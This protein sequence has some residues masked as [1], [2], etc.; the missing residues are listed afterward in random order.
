MERLSTEDYVK[1]CWADVEFYVHGVLDN[2]LVV[3]KY[4]R[5]AVE[6]F[7]EDVNSEQWDYRPDRIEKVFSFFSFLNVD[8]KNSYV[9][10]PLLPF[11]AFFLVNVFGFYFPD[12]EKR[13]YRE[14]LLFIG[15]KNG[16]T[17]FSAAIQLFGLLG[18]GVSV[19]QSLLLSNTAKQA[20]N[21]LNYAKDI[22]NH[23]PALSKRLRPLRNKIVFNDPKR[24][25]F[26]EIFSTVEPSRLE[27]FSPSMAILDEIHGFTDANVFAAIKTGVGART[28]PLILL[29]TTAG[30]KNIGFCNDYLTYHKNLLDGK[31]TDPTAFSLIYQPDESDDLSDPDCWVKANPA[32]GIINSLDDLKASYNQAIHSYVDKYNFI[33][34]H[35]NIFWD[36]PDVWIPEDVLAPLFNDF[37]EEKLKGRDAYIGI[38]LSKTTDLSSVVVLIPDDENSVT[39]VIPKF[40]FANRPDNYIRSNGLDLTPWLTQGFIKKCDTKVID[41]DLIYEDI[42]KLAQQFNIVELSYDPYNAPQLIARLKDYGITCTVFKQTAQKF[43]APLKTLEGMIY[44]KQIQF[45]NPVLKWMF[46]NVVLYVDNNANIKIIKNSQMDSVDGVVAM[47]EAMGS[48]L[49]GKYGDEIMGLSTYLSK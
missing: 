36:T 44:D 27:G 39:Y 19:P 30:S 22:I 25:G 42:I 20:S 33:T 7:V 4:V 17:A 37:D 32:L 2:K 18:D 41:L 34:K 46:S 29:I 15:R 16:K 12:S 26:C 13:R 38:D 10:F 8:H 5:K 45:K 21:A 47:A 14:A 31:I 43:N 23:T 1:K 24:Q 9:Q 48:I 3:G 49:E 28:N 11:Q 35:L 40:Y 6:N